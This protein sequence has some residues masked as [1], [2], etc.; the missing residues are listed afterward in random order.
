MEI[1]GV[2]SGGG[3]RGLALIGALEVMENKGFTFRR[4]AG[5]SAGS[6]VAGFVAA[7]FTSNEIIKLIDNVKFKNLLDNRNTWFPLPFQITKWFL[8]YWRLGLYKGKALEEWLR[9][10]LG[11]KGVYTFSDLPKGSLRL[12][13]SDLTNG[14]LIVL[15]DDLVSYGIPIDSFPVAKAI[16]MSCSLPYFFEPIQLR[17][18]EGKSIIVDGGVLS[19]FPM[20]LFVKGDTKKT[21][22]VVGITLSHKLSEHP[23]HKIKNGIQL[24]EALFETMK[25]AHDTR[26]I[27]RKHENDIIFIPTDNF[28]TTNF[29]L[30][31]EKKDALI[32][33]GRSRATDFLKT[34]TY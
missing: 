3:I 6:I 4:V 26:Y 5:T 19:N 14:R 21:R 34:W 15:P 20:W 23:K 18:L 9:V 30:T 31:K 11:E 32:D 33:L 7:G 17:S 16:R 28:I 1:D 24:F 29:Q 12:V 10:K 13:A 25:E 22:P 2:F 27:S 8:L